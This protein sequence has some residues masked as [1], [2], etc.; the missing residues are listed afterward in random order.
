MKP[1]TLSLLAVL[2]AGIASCTTKITEPTPTQTVDPPSIKKAYDATKGG[3]QITHVYYNQ[4]LNDSLTGVNDEWVVLE[5]SGHTSIDGWVLDAGDDQRFTL[6]GA[7][8]GRLLVYTKEGPTTSNEE[9]VAQHRKVWIW[10]N[11]EPDTAR[12]Y[13]NNGDLIDSMTY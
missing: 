2:A 13:N 4:T 3:V 8:H 1:A 10:N 9:W 12:L 11:S 6:Q 5:S 7:I